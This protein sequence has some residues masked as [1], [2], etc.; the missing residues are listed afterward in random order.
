MTLIVEGPDLVGKSRLVAKLVEELWARYELNCDSHHMTEADAGLLPNGFDALFNKCRIFDRGHMSEVVYGSLFRGKSALSPAQYR[1]I[2]G[3]VMA[4][5][6]AVVVLTATPE[7]Y[8]KLL[9]LHHSRGEL[10]DATK[11]KQVNARYRE[12]AGDGWNGYAPMID[13]HFEISVS[14]QG[15]IQYPSDCKL[16][17]DVVTE[18]YAELQGAEL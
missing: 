2:D 5:G 12:L 13:A 9:Q 1:I 17:V 15:N 14:S 7:A 3:M 18:R 16:L 6:G 11:C 8:E 10:Y 4:R